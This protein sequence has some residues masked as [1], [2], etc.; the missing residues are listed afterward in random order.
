[1]NTEVSVRSILLSISVLFNLS[2]PSHNTGRVEYAITNHVAFFD[3]ESVHQDFHPL[4]DFLNKSPVSYAL[5]ASL[6]IY[7]EVDEEMWS[8]A[9]CSEGQIKL[10]IKG[11]SLAF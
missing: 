4:M 3:K 11:K 5:T 6:T 8:T 1:M 7:A 2:R 10:N 9:C